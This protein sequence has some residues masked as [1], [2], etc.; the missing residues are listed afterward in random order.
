M[1]RRRSRS[2]PAHA[3]RV[4]LVGQSWGGALAAQYL[5]AHSEHVAKAVFAS[6]FLRGKPLPVGT[7]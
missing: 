4:I 3:D 6:A 5:A 7:D 1:R 2:D